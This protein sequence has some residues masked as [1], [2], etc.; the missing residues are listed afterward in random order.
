LLERVMASRA[1]QDRLT[2]AT[3]QAGHITLKEAPAAAG[4][5]FSAPTFSQAVDRPQPSKAPQPGA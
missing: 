4:A 5:E 1:V 3:E 2:A